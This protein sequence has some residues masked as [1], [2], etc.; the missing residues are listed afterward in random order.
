MCSPARPLVLPLS[1]MSFDQLGILATHPRATDEIKEAFAAALHLWVGQRLKRLLGRSTQ[2]ADREDLAH[3]FMIS[4]YAHHLAGWSPGL[5]PVSAWLF[6]RLRSD[7]V[8]FLRKTTRSKGRFVDVDDACV[9]APDTSMD[10]ALEL[11]AERARHKLVDDVI[12]TL[13][14]RRRMVLRRTL[15]GESL[16]DIARDGRLSSSTASREK[17]LAVAALQRAVAGCDDAG[18][19]A[20]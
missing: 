4:C 12:A 6:L 3:E 11:R 20:A 2:A 10:A 9:V 7:V 18:R 15:N 13:P 16:Q 1:R 19:A 14:R 5:C 8:D 17:A